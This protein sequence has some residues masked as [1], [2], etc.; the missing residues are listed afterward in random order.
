MSPSAVSVSEPGSDQETDSVFCE[1]SL[2]NV[3]VSPGLI[4]VAEAAMPAFG[5]LLSGQSIVA[6]AALPCSAS[7]LTGT[8][9][10]SVLLVSSWRL[11]AL[12][13]KFVVFETPRNASD[14]SWLTR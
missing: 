10:N 12:T 11:I 6:V 5:L 4:S 2:V 8:T 14:L 13:K 9:L 7:A 3:T 1:L